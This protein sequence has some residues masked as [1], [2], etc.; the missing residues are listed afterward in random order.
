[1]EGLAASGCGSQEAKC[2]S[3]DPGFLLTSIVLCEQGG[4]GLSGVEICKNAQGF[5]A[6]HGE[7]SVEAD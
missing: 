1:M 6:L 4:G 7:A 2:F 3:V 5:E